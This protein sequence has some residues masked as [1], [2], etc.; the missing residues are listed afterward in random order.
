MAKEKEPKAHQLYKQ[1]GAT[2]IVLNYDSLTDA[3]A[4]N[5][6]EVIWNVFPYAVN[7]T[8]ID[9]EGW[10][11]Q[12]LTTFTQGVDFQH[13]LMPRSTSLGILEVTCLDIITTRRLSDAEISNWGAAGV[14]EDPPGFIENTTDLM[15]VIYG[16]R[17]TF[18]QN[19]NIIG[20][21][22]ALYV[23]IDKETFGSGNPTASDKLHWTRVYWLNGHNIPDPGTVQA[24]NIPATN[25]IVQALTVEE[26][27]LVWMERLRRSYVLQGEL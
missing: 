7:R 13:A 16:E 25:L 21:A 12:E 4:S 2:S 11:K 10:S 20:L 27:D 26:K 8:Y 18:A 23:T 1:L 22:G 15:E 14:G 17:T 24:I 5:G 19:N 3:Y 6:W 9:L